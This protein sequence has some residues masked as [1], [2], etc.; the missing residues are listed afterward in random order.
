MGFA[1]AY[2]ATDLLWAGAEEV[3]KSHMGSAG[4]KLVTMDGG[5]EGQRFEQEITRWIRNNEAHKC[6]RTVRVGTQMMNALGR[7]MDRFPNVTNVL[8]MCDGKVGEINEEFRRLSR[9]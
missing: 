1:L 7:C 8:I 4:E 5:R 6:P 3:D 2:W 9:R